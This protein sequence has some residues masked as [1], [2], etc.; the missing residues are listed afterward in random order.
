MALVTTFLAA[1]LT[2]ARYPTWYQVKVERWRRGEIDWDSRSDSVTAVKNQ[3]KTVP[4]RK[5][6]VYLRLNGLSGI[7]TLAA[8]LSPNRAAALTSP[9]PTDQGMEEAVSADDNNETGA[10]SPWRPTHR[11][12]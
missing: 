9:Q 5:L 6:L 7:C 4:V 1:P 10:P 12:D 8:L 11:I 3:V 2:T